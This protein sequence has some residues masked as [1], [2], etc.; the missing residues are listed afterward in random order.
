MKIRRTNIGEIFYYHP[1]QLGSTSFVTDQNQNITQGFLYAPFGGITT[2]YN[3]NFGNNVIP[4][5]SFNAK[6]L[7]EETGMYYYEARYYAPPVFTSRDAMFEKYFWM[8]PY[9]YCANN[10]VKY[11]DP[12]GE[13]PISAIMEGVGA[14]VISAGVS[15]F[16]NW[17]LDGQDFKTALNNV[18]WKTATADAITTT[19]MSL[20]VSGMGITKTTTKILN[21]KVGKLAL[22]TMKSMLMNISSQLETG[23]DFSDIDLKEEF[24]IATFSTLVV[25][26]MNK[27]A[28]E[29]LTSLKEND[30]KV[31]NKCIKLQRDMNE[32]KN[33]VRIQRDENQVR[34]AKQN[35]KN[36][37]VKYA[38]YQ[39]KN[40]ATCS[41]TQIVS[42]GALNISKNF[43]SNKNEE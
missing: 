7:D 34:I 41:G 42:K 18:A 20:L 35:S 25:K 9:A 29:L 22:E 38:K 4:K 6:E 27:K 37:N 12:S 28:D 43:L 19:A 31:Y 15:F 39:V 13:A 8:T 1:N 30:N 32:G 36:A 2:E 11:V 14:F 5:Y 17:L 16:S 40:N 10:P 26:G 23:K 21:S 3:I 33:D 24:F